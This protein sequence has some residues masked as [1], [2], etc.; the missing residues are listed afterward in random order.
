ME[1]GLYEASC[2]SMSPCKHVCL[3][4]PHACVSYTTVQAL[5][6]V[7]DVVVSISGAAMCEAGGSFTVINFST[8]GGNLPLLTTTSLATATATVFTV[9]EITAGTT[10]AVECSNRGLCNRD[11][12][13]CVCFSGYSPSNGDGGAGLIPDCGYPGAVPPTDCPTGAH[14]HACVPVRGHG[15]ACLRVGREPL[16][17]PLPF[18]FPSLR[19]AWR[20]AFVV[21]VVYAVCM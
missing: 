18:P 8:D 15:C 2:P 17:P 5:P 14:E 21:E 6:T 1:R 19:R 12:G 20:L 10:E 9:E 16:T 13:A 3:S 11:T 4:C 7:G